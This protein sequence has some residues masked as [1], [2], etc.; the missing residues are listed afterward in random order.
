MVFWVVAPCSI[1][2]YTSI[3]RNI[4]R[5]KLKRVRRKIRLKGLAN[6][7]HRMRKGDQALLVG[8]EMATY[9]S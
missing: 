8:P 3:L 4:F 1:F 2:M 9:P 5:T 7:S 6:Q